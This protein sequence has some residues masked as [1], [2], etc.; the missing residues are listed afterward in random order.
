[1]CVVEQFGVTEVS[2][3]GTWTLRAVRLSVAAAH[4]WQWWW[5]RLASAEGPW[6]HR[7]ALPGRTARREQVS[8]E[9][10]N[11]GHGKSQH[12][13]IVCAWWNCHC[14][15]FEPSRQSRSESGSHSRSFLMRVTSSVPMLR[16]RTSSVPMLLPRKSNNCDP[17]S[18]PPRKRSGGSNS[19]KME[20]TCWQIGLALKTTC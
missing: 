3:N 9:I 17:S 19:F 1:M 10:C 7:G 11:C 12:K 16:P 8:E 6:H 15:Q 2:E 5:V 18:V 14:K 13:A 20:I 4:L